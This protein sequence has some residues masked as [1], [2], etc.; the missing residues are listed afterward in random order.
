MALP[1]PL[2][3]Q[4]VAPP[5]VKKI[6]VSPAELQA[7]C[8]S[9]ATTLNTYY[10]DLAEPLVC[11]GLLKG[12]YPFM[13]DLLRHVN[14]DC[15]VEY[16][17]V[18]SYLGSSRP[19]QAA[20]VTSDLIKLNL[21][22]RRILIIDDIVETSSSIIEAK[23]YLARLKPAEIKSIALVS[24]VNHTTEACDWIGVEV[25]D[26]F[27]IGFGLDYMDLY[28]NL[29]YIAEADTDYIAQTRHHLQP[30]G[31]REVKK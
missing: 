4:P 19:Q 13:T 21:K 2:A 16:L 25:I 30:T 12:C 15:D 26:R 10:H 5:I 7:I 8:R 31:A 14:F 1:K 6:L 22:N 18:Q 23:K 17:E 27:L 3:Q 11:V 20:V 28:R 29:P 9:L 24:K